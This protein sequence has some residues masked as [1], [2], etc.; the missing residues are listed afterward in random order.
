MNKQTYWKVICH[1]TRRDSTDHPTEDEALQEAEQVCR[2]HNTST[3]IYECECIGA[4]E[5]LKPP[6]PIWIEQK[7]EY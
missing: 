6:A 2:R 4:Y 1:G 3:F 5:P 7:N